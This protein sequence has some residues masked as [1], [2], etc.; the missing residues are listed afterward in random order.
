MLLLNL[1]RVEAKGFFYMLLTLRETSKSLRHIRAM[2]AYS[3][4]EMEQAISGFK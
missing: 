3:E 1:D 2:K 4:S